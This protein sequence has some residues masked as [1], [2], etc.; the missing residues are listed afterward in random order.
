VTVDLNPR[1]AELLAPVT[2]DAYEQVNW[3]PIRAA[4]IASWSVDRCMA[5]GRARR[6]PD[7]GWMRRR[8]TRRLEVHHGVY[9]KAWIAGRWQPARGAGE[10]AV[11]LIE[12]CTRCHRTG[13]LAGHDRYTA[14]LAELTRRHVRR[15][16]R[17]NWWRR[18]PTP[19]WIWSRT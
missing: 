5:C 6:Q 14:N 2:V 11:D 7:D 10:R 15:V 18:P 4:W 17:R 12:L 8:R 13:L 1:L 3:P 16:R 19:A 9:R